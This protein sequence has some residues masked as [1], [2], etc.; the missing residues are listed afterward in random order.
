MCRRYPGSGYNLT[1]PRD[2][3]KALE[4]LE[5]YKKHNWID[6][7]TRVVFVDLLLYNPNLQ[8]MTQAR[9]PATACV[10][11][12][13]A[14]AC[15]SSAFPHRLPPCACDPCRKTRRQWISSRIS[16]N[17]RRRSNRS[18]SRSKS[19]FVRSRLPPCAR[20]LTFSVL[21]QVGQHSN[22]VLPNRDQIMGRLRL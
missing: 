3:T 6:I 22:R 14:T 17:S 1:I 7:G 12:P 19:S 20:H 2:Y 16:S 8:I 15:Q 21:L 10:G 11:A 5:W 18:R 13:V 4:M 9:H